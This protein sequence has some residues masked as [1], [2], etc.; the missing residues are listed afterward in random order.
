MSQ[1]DLRRSVYIY[2]G[3]RS[4]MNKPILQLVSVH[5]K[6]FIRQPSVI[7]WAFGFPIIIS[8]ILGLAFSQQD[9]IEFRIA[10]IGENS[11]FIENIF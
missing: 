7:F 1:N 3:E 11:A 10:V 6:D 2:D 5:I 4:W 9:Q 8:W